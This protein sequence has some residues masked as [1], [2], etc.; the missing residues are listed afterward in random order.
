MQPINPADVRF[1][2]RCRE[3]RAQL[4]AALYHACHQAP[5]IETLSTPGSSGR[6]VPK[7]RRGCGTPP[8]A[9]CDL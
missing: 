9:A 8:A 3:E 6:G 4:Q 5:V 7:R 1:E 2:A